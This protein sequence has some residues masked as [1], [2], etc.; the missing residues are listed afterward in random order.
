MG[1]HIGTLESQLTNAK[2]AIE[3][4]LRARETEAAALRETV[5]RLEAELSQALRERDVAAA[6]LH[7]ASEAHAVVLRNEIERFA[8]Q[9]AAALAERDSALAERDAAL[10]S[11]ESSTARVEESSHLLFFAAAGRGYVL[12]ERPGPA[13]AVGDV[14]DTSADG[15]TACACVRK[16][17]RPPI[18]EPTLRCAYLL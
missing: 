12:L 11:F 7:A 3:A 15:G 6:Q 16:V 13:P 8:P 2:A 9:L 14:V 17:A 4:S 5:M 1:A 18:P 10:A